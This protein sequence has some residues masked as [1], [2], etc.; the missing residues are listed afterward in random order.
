MTSAVWC[1]PL[2][3][4]RIRVAQVITRFIA[5]A[6]G[7]ALR[8]AMALDPD[9]FETVF[10]TGPGGPLTDRAAA[11]GFEVLILRHMKPELAA[12]EAFAGAREIR[13]LLEV[14]GFDVVHT[15]STKAGALGRF[16]A[17]AAGVPAVVHTFHGF[18]FHDFQSPLRRAAYIAAERRLG[19]M[20][21]RFIA[22]GVSVAA[23]AVR[24]RLA[25]PERMR[26]IPVS[27]DGRSVAQTAET[28][29]RARQRL[30]IPEHVGLLGTVGRLDSQ[31]APHHF[32]EAMAL[33]GRPDVHAVWIGDGPLRSETESL[34]RRRGLDGRVHLVGERSD[35][36]DL[37]PGLDVFVMTSLY[38]GLPCSI[39]EAMRCG[40]PVVASAV[41]GVPELVVPGQTG[42]LVPP[43]RPAAVAAAAGHLL[44][45]PDERHRMAEQA[46]F[47]VA[48]RFVAADAGLALGALYEEVL[49]SPP[50]ALHMFGSRSA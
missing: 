36:A 41:N 15:H 4:P 8:G 28:R 29:A 9:R 49:D 16:A 7:V 35:V 27:I 14:G 6:G 46:R 2:P 11:A 37:L 5:G 25:V 24:L 48:G 30:G 33:L 45:H 21:D 32:V 23:E 1:G 19:R 43:A 18:P 31:K 3:R 10:I 42:F 50:P 39:V 13:T 38:E 22:V 47:A 44:D 20:T 40:L 34:V 17:R 12:G 26:V